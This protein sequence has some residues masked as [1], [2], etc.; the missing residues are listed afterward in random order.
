MAFLDRG[1][2]RPPPVEVHL[3]AQP[4]ASWVAFLIPLAP[5]PAIT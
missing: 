2:N 4:H 3:Y 1:S 5:P